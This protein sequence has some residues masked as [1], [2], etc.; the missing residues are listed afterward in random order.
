MDRGTR[1]GVCDD[2]EVRGGFL[3]RLLI[4]SGVF[5]PGFPW[6]SFFFLCGLKD[7]LAI[8]LVS[9]F[10]WAFEGLWFASVLFMGGALLG[11]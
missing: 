4:S 8:S 2:G 10:S 5:L 1:R 3:G 6:F 11:F 9:F 7:S